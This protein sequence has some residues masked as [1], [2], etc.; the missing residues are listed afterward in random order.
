MKL[1]FFKKKNKFESWDGKKISPKKIDVNH[2][3]GPFDRKNQIW[4]KHEDQFLTNQILNDEFFLK[5]SITQND[6]KENNN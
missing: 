2:C 6:P 5:E 4:K 1:N 3:P